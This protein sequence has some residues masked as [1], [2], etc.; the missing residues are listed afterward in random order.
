MWLK[1]LVCVALALTNLLLRWLVWRDQSRYPSKCRP[2]DILQNLMSGVFYYKVLNLC[3][4]NSSCFFFV[5]KTMTSVVATLINIFSIWKTL[6]VLQKTHIKVVAGAIYTYLFFFLYIQSPLPLE[7]KKLFNLFFP[8][9]IRAQTTLQW[10]IL[11]DYSNVRIV[12][13]MIKK[14]HTLPIVYTMLVKIL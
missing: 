10:Y 11:Q 6:R 1:W 12:F 14:R 4:S 13:N 8:Q 2:R 3:R 7:N 9:Q 5:L